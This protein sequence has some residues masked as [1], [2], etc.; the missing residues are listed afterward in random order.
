[1]AFETARPSAASRGY[2][3]EHQARRRSLAP[4]VA[5]GRVRCW[6][7]RERIGRG[8]A[9][10]LGHRDDRSLPTEPEHEECNKRAAGQLGAQRAAMRRHDPEHRPMTDWSS[11]DTH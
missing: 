11:Q 8:E 4:S 7:C 3:P 1:M 10:V 2:G 5:T 6:R 9:W